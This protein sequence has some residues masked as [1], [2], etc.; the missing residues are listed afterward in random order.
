MKE[1]ISN[2]L[3]E[4]GSAQECMCTV[5]CLIE[6]LD[7]TF[8]QVEQCAFD[9]INI[10]DKMIGLIY[11]GQRILGMDKNEKK[12]LQDIFTQLLLQINRFGDSTHDME[13]T[14]ANQGIIVGDLKSAIMQISDQLDQTSACAELL[15]TLS[16]DIY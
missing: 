12:E 4:L 10:S 15:L 13:N 9:E 14:I 7:E 6:S 11:E 2:K 1:M 16:D 5:N 3:K 8:L